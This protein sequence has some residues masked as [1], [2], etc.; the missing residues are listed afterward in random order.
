[1][2]RA[3]G[4]GGEAAESDAGAELDDAR[5]AETSAEGLVGRHEARQ[6]LRALP[7]AAEPRGCRHRVVLVEEV[8]VGPLVVRG[9]AR[10]IPV[11]VG[12]GRAGDVATGDAQRHV[13]ERERVRREALTHDHARRARRPMTRP[14]ARVSSPFSGK[15]TR[16]KYRARCVSAHARPFVCNPPLGSCARSL[17]RR[18]QTPPRH[19]GVRRD[20]HDVPQGLHGVPLRCPTRASFRSSHPPPLLLARSDIVRMLHPACANAA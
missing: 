4:G 19:Y 6:H 15:A 17:P 8:R 18:I 14:A 5:T 3:R 12:R 10:G 13:P 7:R 16:G 1:M 20:P 11:R 2:T 9:D